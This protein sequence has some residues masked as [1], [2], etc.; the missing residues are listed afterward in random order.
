MCQKECVN[1]V[2]LCRG[3]SRIKDKLN[4]YLLLLVQPKAVQA[5]FLITISFNVNDLLL[6]LSK[7]FFF[8]LLSL[9][10]FIVAFY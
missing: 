5:N 1:K 9:V 8:S 10:L 6:L 7:L 3:Q 4:R 2:R